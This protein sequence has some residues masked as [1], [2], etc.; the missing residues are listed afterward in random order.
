M[1]SLNIIDA[2]AASIQGLGRYGSQRYGIA[3]GGA[4]DRMALAEANALTGQP[5]GGAAIEIGPLP[6]R[7]GVSGGAVR[8]ALSGADRELLIDGRSVP[9]GATHVADKGVVVT[10]RGA[11]NGQ[12]SYLSVQGGLQGRDGQAPAASNGFD[13]SQSMRAWV[14][15]ANDWIAVKPAATGQQENRLRP[16]RRSASPIRVVLGP[17]LD[18]FSEEAVSRFLAT[19]WAVS[20]ASNRM[21]YLLEGGRVELQKGFNIVSDGTVTGNIQI[22]GNGQPLAIL[23]D[24]GTVGGYPKIATIISADIGRFAQAP[25]AG[26]ITFEAVSVIEAQ[27][28]ARDFAFALANVKPRVET[29]QPF[30]PVSLAALLDSNIAG[31][32]FNPIDWL[33]ETNL[34]FVATRSSL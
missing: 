33:S 19:P 7:L 24:R 29:V 2:G 8:I 28:I 6:I 9:L 14:L 10:V 32:A 20:H 17:Q 11:R 3:P 4:M 30:Q 21:A 16:Q 23:R 18:Y 22:A 25:V 31:D 5:A 26:R 13:I 34:S 27:S 12:F 1:P 15:I